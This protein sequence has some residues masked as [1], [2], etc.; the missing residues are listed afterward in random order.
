MDSKPNKQMNSFDSKELTTTPPRPNK[1][2]KNQTNKQGKFQ[3][4]R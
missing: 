4:T 2:K 3:N 1:K